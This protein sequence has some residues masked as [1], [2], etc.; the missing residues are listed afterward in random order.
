MTP[1]PLLNLVT[2]CK[3]F[4]SLARPPTSR[5]TSLVQRQRFFYIGLAVGKKS[6][7][8]IQQAGIAQELWIRTK[9]F[10]FPLPLQQ[11]LPEL[12]V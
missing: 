7:G 6:C 3:H 2:S 10:T 11:A 4:A 1:L 5:V 8:I 12:E 9:R